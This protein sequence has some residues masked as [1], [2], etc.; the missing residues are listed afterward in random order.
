MDM[1]R[2]ETARQQWESAVESVPQFICLLDRDC[3][4]I[5]ANRTVERWKLGIDVEQ[6][7]GLGL[8]QV[9]HRDCDDPRCYLRR[10]GERA[11][12]ALA[13]GRRANCDAWDPLLKR[14]F[15]IR[16]RRPTPT[17]QRK[18]Y[19]SD[20]FAVVTVDDVT[21]FKAIENESGQLTQALDQRVLHEQGKRTPAEQAHSHII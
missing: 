10:F 20:V 13:K 19:L 8:H 21:E 7:G 12:V 14:H 16:A 18:D 5:R 3:R 6:V 4:V 2:L 15:L 1:R 11:T 9:L 17:Q